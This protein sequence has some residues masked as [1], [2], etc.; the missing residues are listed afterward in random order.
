MAKTAKKSFATTNGY[1]FT[2]DAKNASVVKGF[3]DV[4]FG[5]NGGRR[6]L[7][8]TKSGQYLARAIAERAHGDISGK[9]VS[10]K[11]GNQLNLTEKNL[12]VL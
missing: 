3:G 8:N 1:T 4:C 6:Y 9:V 12:L 7:R 11:D 2:V 5:I 10:Y